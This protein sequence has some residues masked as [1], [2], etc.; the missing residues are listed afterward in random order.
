MSRS[1]HQDLEDSRILDLLKMALI[2]CGSRALRC[3]WKAGRRL[4][5]P[6]KLLF[7]RVFISN[8]PIS[9]VRAMAV[10]DCA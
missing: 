10:G 8:T 5:P 1:R 3:G 6:L 2:L 9:S 4:L 7:I